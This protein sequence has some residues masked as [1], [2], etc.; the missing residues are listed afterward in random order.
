MP[1]KEPS[2]NDIPPHEHSIFNEKNKEKK[3]MAATTKPLNIH[4]RMFEVMKSVKYI[5]KGDRKVNGQYTFVSHDAVVEKLR[6]A[7]IENGILPIATIVNHTQ[8]GNR[9]EVDIEVKFCNIDDPSDFI[10]V[11][12]FGYGIDNQDKGPG[13]AVSYAV[14]YCFLKTF[15]L[16]TGDDPEKDNIDFEKSKANGNGKTYPSNPLNGSHSQNQQYKGN[17]LD[18]K[19]ALERAVKPLLPAVNKQLTDCGLDIFDTE[20]EI[21]AFVQNELK[22]TDKLTLAAVEHIRKNAHDSIKWIVGLVE[23][24]SMS[25]APPVLEGVF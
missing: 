24:K 16:E 22:E 11:N 5:Q 14:K 9:S 1:K 7:F 20:A 4:Q 19:A 21:I 25:D 17:N 6:P 8:E 10:T 12:G 13:K 15:C 3:T 18:L 2:I 23:T